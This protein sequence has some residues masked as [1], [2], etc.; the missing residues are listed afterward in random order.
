MQ[1]EGGEEQQAFQCGGGAVVVAKHSLASDHTND[2][3]DHD[4]RDDGYDD[5]SE[6]ASYDG[7]WS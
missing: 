6:D 7:Q 2:D 5:L 1:S 3:H 4:G